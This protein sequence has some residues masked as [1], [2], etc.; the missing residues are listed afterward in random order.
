M[1]CLW[2][3]TDRKLKSCV[4][5]KSLNSCGTEGKSSIEAW[6]CQKHWKK[7]EIRGFNG[8]MVA[9]QAFHSIGF[10]RQWY[11]GCNLK[12]YFKKY[13]P[14]LPFKTC[15]SSL[16][17]GSSLF[18]LTGFIFQMNFVFSDLFLCSKGFVQAPSSFL[19]DL[20]ATF[21]TLKLSSLFLGSATP[22]TT[23]STRSLHP[24]VYM[25]IAWGICNECYLRPTQTKYLCL[26]YQF[27]YALNEL[28]VDIISDIGKPVAP[29][30]MFIPTYKLK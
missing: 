18:R 12:M 13:H 5:S 20:S 29:Y 4:Y 14:C 2:K 7:M 16:C 17:Y 8:R 21:W 22:S 28:Q 27:Q 6:L 19:P 3:V 9:P 23:M 25:G 15:V 30:Q 1:L 26:E 24:I 10:W 11:Y